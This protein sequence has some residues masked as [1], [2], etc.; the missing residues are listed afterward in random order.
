MKYFL[1]HTQVMMILVFIVHWQLLPTS[2]SIVNKEKLDIIIKH[3]DDDDDDVSDIVK[4]VATE[5]TFNWWLE[6]NFGGREQ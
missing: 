2:V 5:N 6:N 1:D 3:T 4:H